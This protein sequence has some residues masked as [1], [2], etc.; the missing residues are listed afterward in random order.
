ML[1]L[2]RD[3]YLGMISHA[4][5]GLPEEA[6]GLLAATAPAD[7][8]EVRKTYPCRNRAASAR[9]YEVDSRDFL[10]ADRDAESEGLQIV[11][12]YHSHTHTDAYPSPTDV[13][14]APDPEWHYLIVSLRE[15]EPVVRSYRIVD[16]QVTEEPVVVDDQ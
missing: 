4:L 13:R 10:H 6:C 16:G 1:R 12:V 14:Q 3:H 7:G 8:V 5:D 11:G 9:V 2:G 15:P